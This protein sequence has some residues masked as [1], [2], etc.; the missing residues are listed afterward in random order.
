M[1]LRIVCRDNGGTNHGGSNKAIREVF[2][3][4]YL[5]KCLLILNSAVCVKVTVTK[6]WFSCGFDILLLQAVL[7]VLPQ[8]RIFSISPVFGFASGGVEGPL[9][10]PPVCSSVLQLTFKTDFFVWIELDAPFRLI[11]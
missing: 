11:S 10:S 7:F 9:P 3:Q 6:I 8:P 4:V 1:P 2:I 5:I